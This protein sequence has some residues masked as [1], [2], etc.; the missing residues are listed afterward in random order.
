MGPGSFVYKGI[1]FVEQDAGS[2][3]LTVIEISQSSGELHR[4][5]LPLLV[6][7]DLFLKM[8]L[9]TS[10]PDP[11]PLI[12]NGIDS[13]PPLISYKKNPLENIWKTLRVTSVLYN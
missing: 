6:P 1:R 9:T 10:L 5:N 3:R 13:I 7:G 11:L 8:P 12:H 2:F 4:F